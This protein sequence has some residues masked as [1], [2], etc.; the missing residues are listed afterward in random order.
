M[1]RGCGHLEMWRSCQPASTGTTEHE[2]WG[3]YSVGSRYQ[4]TTGEDTADWEDLVHAVV[5]YKVCELVIA[6]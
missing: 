6:L 5:N 4:A 2:N 3:I 1:A